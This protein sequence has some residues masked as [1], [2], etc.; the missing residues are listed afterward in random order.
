MD[1]PSSA[2]P[3]RNGF[4]TGTCAA[5]AAKAATLLLL[6]GR[7]LPEISVTL[8]D[9]MSVCLPVEWCRLSDGSAQAAI[10]KRS[11]DDPD[12]TDGAL[13]V[14]HVTQTNGAEVEIVAGDGVG[15]VTK[16]GLAVPPGEPAINP[17]PR[18]MIRTAVREISAKPVR[19]T[20][21]VPDG[22][23]LAEQT[24][25]PRLGI[26]GG[27]SILGTSGIVRPFSHSALQDSL[28]CAL[29]VAAA[30]GFHDVILVPGRIGERAAYRHMVFEEEQL[31]EV[32]NEWGF[33]LDRVTE[34]SFRA[35]LVMGHPGKLAKPAHGDWDTHSSRSRSAAPFVRALLNE[36]L[37]RTVAGASTVEAIFQHLAH[38]DGSELARVLAARIHEAVLERTQYRF[39]LG[40]AL[41]NLQGDLLGTHGEVDRWLRQSP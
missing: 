22:Q 40:V 26:V 32:S 13:I 5:A 12:V 8:P 29:R 4:T 23:R 36:H 17:A 14:A 28:V 11:G 41:V 20:V 9:G 15:T 25:N 21:S 38:E 19:V 3:L 16:P 2:G 18:G 6:T 35:V 24:F 37:G 33:M 34:G 27:I 30:S 31:I 1:V 39:V 10:R 7:E